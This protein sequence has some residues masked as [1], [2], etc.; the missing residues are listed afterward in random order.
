MDIFTQLFWIFFLLFIISSGYLLCCTKK[1]NIFYLQI[2][3]G[4]GMF[5]TSKI[6]RNFLG[7]V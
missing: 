3:S 6:G 1:S 7:L 2:A 4:C 5:A